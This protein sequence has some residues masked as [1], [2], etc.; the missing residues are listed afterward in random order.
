MV[1]T[2]PDLP[3][4]RST[5][6]RSSPMPR[7]AIWFPW[8]RRQRLDPRPPH[9][10]AHRIESTGGAWVELE[11]Y[12]WRDSSSRDCLHESFGRTRG[13][14]VDG[15]PRHGDL[16]VRRTNEE[17]V[18]GHCGSSARDVKGILRSERGHGES[19]AI[20]ILA[21]AYI[22]SVSFIVIALST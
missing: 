22:L 1:L 18:A 17:Y 6:S 10:V 8:L 3:R 2:T 16:A 20:L 19:G 7:R 5:T 12:L 15:N 11:R 13:D 14:H 9:D 4:A 21:L